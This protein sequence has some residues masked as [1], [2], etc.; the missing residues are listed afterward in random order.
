MN[1]HLYALIQ[2]Y[3][4]PARAHEVVSLHP[5][6]NFAGPTG[7]GK[8]TLVT[9]LTQTGDYAPVVSD[10]TR[11]PR[12][13]NDG[14]EVNG[15]SYWFINEDEAIDKVA[16]HEY[17]EVKA[18]HQK[19]MYGTSIRSYERVV[20]T[21]RTPLLEI[22]VQ[23]MEDLMDRFAEFESVFLLPPSFEIWQKR[24]DG[25]GQ[26]QSEEKIQRLKSACAEIKVLIDN[27]R[28]LPVVNVEVVETAELIMSGEYRKDT[29]RA[30]ALA[31]AK[32]IL[33]QTEVFLSQQ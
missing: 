9:Y 26:M 21:G 32:E 31:T 24:L 29:Y 3:Q 17:I 14:H 20:D 13:H 10:T 16:D 18:V 27:P 28:F 23:G 2:E 30:S 11:L 33:A 25:R 8:G 4:A 7:A 19:T 22:D 6:L 5:S 15:V 1:E 12:P